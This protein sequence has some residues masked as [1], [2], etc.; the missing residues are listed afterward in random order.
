MPKLNDNDNQKLF[1]SL[2][3]D[4][5]DKDGPMK[6]LHDLNPVRLKYLEKKVELKN[7]IV[8]DIGCG[9]GIL[10]ESVAKAGA[11]VVGIDTSTELVQIARHHAALENLEIR[12]E[13]NSV[14]DLARKE[15][16]KYDVVL[17]MEL[18]EHVDDIYELL[19]GC[20][21]LLKRE[22]I[23]CVST[24]NRSVWSYLFGVLA[25]EDLLK[26]VPKGTHDYNKFIKPSEMREMLENNNFSISDIQ[27]LKF[28]P[29]S[30][31][32]KLSTFSKI[33]YFITALLNE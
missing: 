31:T 11:S 20:A 25:A 23:L 29:I 10:S 28:N 15:S 8:A 19:S 30:N 17:C 32:F 6:T 7:A 3:N 22:G 24:L 18:V 13:S 21:K 16:G 14:S 5:W 1:N 2:A 4:W 26:I 33:N 12:Y 9:G 27:G